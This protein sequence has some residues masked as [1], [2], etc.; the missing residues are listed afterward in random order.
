MAGKK[1]KSSW[2]STDRYKP[3]KCEI[4]KFRENHK[5]TVAL[6][7]QPIV[8]A[9]SFFYED[10]QNALSIITFLSTSRSHAFFY[11]FRQIISIILI[12]IHDHAKMK[13]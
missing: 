3:L 9:C 12:M 11:K 8:M 6:I 5:I 1:G 7:R 10:K 4:G 2:T 13:E